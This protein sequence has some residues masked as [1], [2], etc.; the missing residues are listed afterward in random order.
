MQT[1]NMTTVP[2]DSDRFHRVLDL[3]C[4]QQLC[5][6]VSA[7]V[8]ATT[9]A[10][11]TKA[12]V[13]IRHEDGSM[14]EGL[15][16]ECG[17]KHGQGTFKTEIYISGIVG[18]ENS[19][20]AKWTEMSGEWCNGLLHGQAVMREMSDKGVVRVVHDG[21]WD[22]GVA[23]VQAVQDRSAVERL[24]MASLTTSQEFDFMEMCDNQNRLPWSC[25]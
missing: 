17:E 7:N 16:N 5:S 18:D 21:M 19:H 4:P 25:D 3:I 13:S 9:K 23:V 10:A 15:V 24:I 6:F 22:T 20:L 1:T 12:P 2:F 14:Y 8:A 11:A